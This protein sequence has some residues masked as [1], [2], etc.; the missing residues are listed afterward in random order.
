MVSLTAIGTS[1][2]W[3]RSLGS[4]KP[5]MDAEERRRVL[6][7][8]IAANNQRRQRE[9]L[10]SRLPTHLSQVLGGSPCIYSVEMDPIL[11]RFVPFN[12]SGIGSEEF[13]PPHYEYAEVAWESKMLAL[14]PRLILPRLAGKAFLLLESPRY[15]P[16]IPLFVVEF[17]WAAPILKDLWTYCSRGLLLAEQDL[18]AGVLI[19]TS[20]GYL[21]E[22]FNPKEI[23]CE[24]A[25]WPTQPEPPVGL[26]TECPQ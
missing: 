18:R 25:L 6:F 1:A 20:G 23:V 15:Y 14:L 4:E 22:D 13:L 24:L 3:S 7:E 9:K 5:T 11:R 19:G 17:R 26:P 2:C 12:R 16:D 10:L 8:K 21:P